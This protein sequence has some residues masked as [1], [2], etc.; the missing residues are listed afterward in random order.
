MGIIDSGIDINHLDFKDS[1]G[2]TRIKYLWDMTKPTAPNTPQPYAYGQE[3]NDVDIMGGLAASHTG[4]DQ[5]GHGTYV[6]GI[7]AGNGSAVGD[8]Y[9]RQEVSGKQ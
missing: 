5:F 6:T 7:A 1:T 4:E 3:W 9:K 2:Y 8:V